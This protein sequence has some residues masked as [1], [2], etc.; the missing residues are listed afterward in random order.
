MELPSLLISTP[1]LPNLVKF[2]RQNPK[3]N[4]AVKLL[5]IF[6]FPAVKFFQFSLTAKISVCAIIYSTGMSLFT[7]L[8]PTSA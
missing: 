3:G 7:F 1:S 4:G 8:L 6:L 2:V 5:F